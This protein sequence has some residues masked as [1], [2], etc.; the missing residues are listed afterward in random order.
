MLFTLDDVS[1]SKSFAALASNLIEN[2]EEAI[3]S[4][5]DKVSLWK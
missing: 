4:I 2:L 5:E 1:N 3:N